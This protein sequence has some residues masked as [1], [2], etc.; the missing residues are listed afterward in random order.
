MRV[1]ALA[2]RHTHTR[3]TRSAT[4][5]RRISKQKRI[6]LCAELGRRC[7][8][9][10]LKFQLRKQILVF[11]DSHEAC[12]DEWCDANFFFVLFVSLFIIHTFSYLPY[13]LPKPKKSSVNHC[14]TNGSLALLVV[15]WRIWECAAR[16]TVLKCNFVKS[17][18]VCSPDSCYANWIRVAVATRPNSPAKSDE[19]E[20]V[21][22]AR[23]C[24]F[25]W[26][27]SFFPLFKYRNVGNPFGAQ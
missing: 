10:K 5:N 22:E 16:R 11:L 20:S 8:K 13:N 15:V 18:A 9:I 17:V 3:Y 25:L 23:K 26:S 1:R 24:Q 4:L 19:D 2:L 27:N 7:L 21:L 12:D 6:F 14:A